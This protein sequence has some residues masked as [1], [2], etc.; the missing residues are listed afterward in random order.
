MS[1]IFCCVAEAV[2]GCQDLPTSDP[3]VIT[4]RD[5]IIICCSTTITDAA[6]GGV[7]SH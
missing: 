5:I 4:K 7:F 1:S 6:G 2:V 3:S